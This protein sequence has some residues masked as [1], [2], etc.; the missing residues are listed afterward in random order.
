VEEW[1]PV[2]K[3]SHRNIHKYALTSPHGKSHNQI[4]HILIDRRWLSNVLDLLSFRGND[5]NSDH[6]LVVTK[7]RERLAVNKQATQ[8]FDGERFNLREMSWGLKTLSD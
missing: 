2:R 4:D 1:N 7:F 8:Y 5:Y 3:S 6:S